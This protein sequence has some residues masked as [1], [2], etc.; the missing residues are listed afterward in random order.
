LLADATYAVDKM[1]RE[2]MPLAPQPLWSEDDAG[3]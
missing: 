2:L 3:G 1:L